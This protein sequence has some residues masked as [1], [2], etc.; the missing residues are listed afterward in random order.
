ML[1]SSNIF[2]SNSSLSFE[3]IDQRE[4]KYAQVVSKAF[5]R[6]IKPLYGD[7]TEALSKIFRGLDRTGELLL[8]NGTPAGILV[9]KNKPTNEFKDFGIENSTEIKTLMLIDPERSSG[10]G[11]GSHLMNRVDEVAISSKAF[12]EHVTVSGNKEDSMSFFKKKGFETVLIW[13]D[14]YVHNSDEH[15]MN[16]ILCS[17]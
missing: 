7:Q 1:S 11:L 6:Q 15:L 4:P 10:R 16:R 17:K 5:N 9:Y 3:R 13:K 8:E 14:I 2:P 12:G